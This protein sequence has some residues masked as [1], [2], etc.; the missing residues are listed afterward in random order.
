MQFNHN[1]IINALSKQIPTFILRYED[2]VED[3]EPV[4]MNVFR[5]LL[6][7]PSIEGTIVEKR[8]QDISEQG[9]KE[10]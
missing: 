3:P 8:I 6:D 4:L 5:F 9:K 10:N 7:A 2:L 1:Y